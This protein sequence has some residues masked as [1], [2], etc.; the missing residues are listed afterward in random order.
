V[1]ARTSNVRGPRHRQWADFLL[2]RLTS[3][4]G[5][6][7]T[8]PVTGTSPLVTAVLTLAGNSYSAR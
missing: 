6:R 7:D 1:R 3:S 5:Y 4:V 2:P 8:F